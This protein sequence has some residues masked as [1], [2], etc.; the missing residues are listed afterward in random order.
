MSVH[1]CLPSIARD[2]AIRSMERIAARDNFSATCLET[3]L[4]INQIHQCCQLLNGG[5]SA[6]EDRPT[7][8]HRPRASLTAA[9]QGTVIIRGHAPSDIDSPIAEN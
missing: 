1:G 8:T 9:L 6:G 3:V 4:H 5:S 2:G 7:S